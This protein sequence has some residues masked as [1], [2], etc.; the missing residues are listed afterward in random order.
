MSKLFLGGIPTAPDVKILREALGEI[1]IDTLIP[2]ERVEMITGL[3]RKSP[4]YRCITSAW[5]KEMLRQYNV[6]IGAISGEGFKVLSSSERLTTNYSGFRQ[7]VRK[8]A[9]HL[10]KVT[11]IRS[12]ELTDSERAKREH[13]QRIGAVIMDQSS[14]LTRLIEPPKARE[15]V[16]RLKS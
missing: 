5:R 1:M 9:R 3:S 8:Q 15:Q 4:R 2:H 10:R 11:M 12:E 6:E 13:L 16:S 7:G 14:Q